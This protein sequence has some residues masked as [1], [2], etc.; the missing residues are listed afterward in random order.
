MH[1]TIFVQTKY[2]IKIHIFV[3]E[4]LPDKIVKMYYFFQIMKPLESV[5]E[6]DGFLLTVSYGPLLGIYSL[7]IEH[8]ELVNK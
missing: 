3:Y 8:I 7:D 1:N 2:V 5:L 6:K 4:V